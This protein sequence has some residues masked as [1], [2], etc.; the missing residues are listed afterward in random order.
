MEYHALNKYIE[1]NYRNSAEKMHTAYNIAC[2]ILACCFGILLIRGVAALHA[3]EVYRFEHLSLEEGISHNLAYCICQDH[4]GMMWFGTMYGLVKYDGYSYTVF[5]HDPDDAGS[6]SNDDIVSLY[7]DRSGN[8]WIGTFEGGLNRLD[9]ASGKFERY[10]H[11]KDR[12]GSIAQGTVWAICGDREGRLWFGTNGGGLDMFDSAA[13]TF[14]HYRNDPANGNSLSGDFIFSIA[15]DDSNC[16]WIGTRNTGLDRFDAGRKKFSH[17]RHHEGNAGSLCSDNIRT[18]YFDRGGRLWIGTL[19]GGV[20]C[21]DARNGTFIHHSHDAKNPASI[22]VDYVTA[23]AED[24]SG[25]FWFGTPYGLERYDPLANSFV[26]LTHSDADP[27]S[28]SSNNIVALLQ[29]RSGVLWIGSYLGGIDKYVP[30]ENRFREYHH[31]P[32]NSASLD[33]NNVTALLE[34]HAGILWIGTGRGLN[35]FNDAEETFQRTALERNSGTSSGEYSVTSLAENPRGELLVGTTNGLALLDSK[36]GNA[37][38]Y[39]HSSGDISSLCSNSVTAIHAPRDTAAE[40]SPGIWIGTA[41]GLDLFDPVKKTFTHFIHNE[42]DSL[43]LN[44]DYIM[45]IHSDDEGALWVGTFSGLNRLRKDRSGFDHIAMNPDIPSGL[46][47]NYLLSMYDDHRGSLWIGTGGGLNRYSKSGGTFSHFFRKDGLPNDVICGITE[48]RPGILWLSTNNGISRFDVQAKTFANFTIAD[49]LQS[50]MF[51]KGSY[52][53]RKNGDLVFGGINGFNI[54]HAQA[55][56]PSSFIPPV[57]I[58]SCSVAG[59]GEIGISDDIRGSLSIRLPYDQN[60]LAIA[61]ASLDYVQ[62]EKNRYAFTLEG[63]DG[64][65]IQGGA[66]HSAEYMNLPPGEYRFLV[67]GTNHDGIWNITPAEL[68]IAISPPFWRTWWFYSLTAVLC[69]V[70]IVSGHT[71]RLR[72]KVRRLNEMERVRNDENKLVRKR[73]ADDFHDEF[74]HKLTKIYLLSQVIKRSLDPVSADLAGHLDKISQTSND[75]SMGMRDF[76][77]TL[78]PDRDTLYDV[79]VRLKDFGD[80]L[81]N[82][83]NCGF[84]VSGISKDFEDIQLAVDWRR[85]LL[86]IFKEAMTNVVKHS[87]CGNVTLNIACSGGTLE[88]CLHDDGKG[89]TGDCDSGGQ[90]LTSMRNRAE[91]INGK[92]AIESAP[93]RG[94]T[95]RFTG[96]LPTV[97]ESKPDRKL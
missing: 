82:Y 44:H 8:L 50:N 65:W 18:L 39:R 13:N 68:R 81:F 57:I 26:R 58:T 28:L 92:L 25:N 95:V 73:A 69:C 86:L 62:P 48:E 32:A 34:D 52:C 55:T 3:E 2:R 21:C 42:R 76:L 31:V 64:G 46:S 30:G 67:R 90:G 79:A 83:G 97:N 16:L 61:F 94:T 72:G 51:L 29:D 56:P 35:K 77:W 17:F 85:H 43:S 74:G 59:R 71:Y 89:F 87:G 14:I 23:I 54:V 19:G 24:N 66:G 45:S 38:F 20:D 22:A 78:N 80:E 84:R 9:H 88:V 33:D 63:F 47:N 11:N 27:N 70:V 60:N 49:G 36:R 6:L 40:S 10:L 37:V 7:E 41:S 53:R 5:R 91:K 12:P 15:R 93:G 96:I 4:R 75:L 1:G